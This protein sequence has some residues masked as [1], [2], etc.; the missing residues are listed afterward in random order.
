VRQGL[1]LLI[2]GEADAE[3]GRQL[4]LSTRTVETTART[5]SRSCAAAR[6]PSSSATRSSTTW[7]TSEDAAD[8]LPAAGGSLQA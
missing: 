3:I 4:Y 8:P 7:S 5:S 2:D 1:R 6:A